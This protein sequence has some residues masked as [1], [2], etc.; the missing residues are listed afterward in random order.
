MLTHSRTHALTHSLTHPLRHTHHTTPHH[1][2]L[3][4]C[5]QF[6]ISLCNAVMYECTDSVNIRMGCVSECVSEERGGKGPIAKS[7][8]R[9]AGLKFLLT[10]STI[11]GN[12]R[13]QN[14]A[15]VI[16]IR[17]YIKSFYHI[18]ERERIK[19]ETGAMIMTSLTSFTDSLRRAKRYLGPAFIISYLVIYIIY[20]SLC[21]HS[22]TLMYF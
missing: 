16:L 11:I 17:N 20:H 1:S 18:N 6:G 5:N 13:S 4:S 22:I 8:G 10:R 3:L 21:Y 19:R 2:L 12:G 9:R 14:N 7:R 15:R